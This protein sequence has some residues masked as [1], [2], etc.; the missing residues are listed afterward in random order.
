M[1]SF[2]TFVFPVHSYSLCPLTT[3]GL[4]LPIPPVLTTPIMDADAMKKRRARVRMD[5]FCIATSFPL[6][7]S[8]HPAPAP[9]ASQRS[10]KELLGLFHC[11]WFS[12]VSISLLA[13]VMWRGE[14]SGAAA[15]SCP[16][17][18]SLGSPGPRAR[19]A[20]GV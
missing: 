13:L 8:Q 15:A 20:P 9:A 7:T 18:P 2:C 16:C 10:V 17:Q 14:G 5:P 6:N 1:Y 4:A 3:M 19:A 11:I 12:A